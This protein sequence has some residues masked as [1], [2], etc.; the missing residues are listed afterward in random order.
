MPSALKYSKI[1]FYIITIVMKLSLL[2]RYEDELVSVSCLTSAQTIL[3][4]LLQ[5]FSLL[6][7]HFLRKKM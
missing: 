1:L 2:L 4:M 5:F 3:M 7:F 6:N